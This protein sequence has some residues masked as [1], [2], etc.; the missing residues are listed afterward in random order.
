MVS[1]VAGHSSGIKANALHDYSYVWNGDSGASI[2][3]VGIGT[4][5]INPKDGLSG[6]YVGTDSAASILE[7]KADV[8]SLTAYALSSDLSSKQ[9]KLSEA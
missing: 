9:D 3:S 1:G 8:S 7:R 4:Y 5:N 6:F 2:S